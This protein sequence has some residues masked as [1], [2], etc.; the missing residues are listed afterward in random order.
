[1]TIRLSQRADLRLQLNS[2]GVFIK[3]REMLYNFSTFL[4]SCVQFHA[5]WMCNISGHKLYFSVFFK[6]IL[7]MIIGMEI[8]LSN[9]ELNWFDISSYSCTIFYILYN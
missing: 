8:I 5:I 2:L 1:M 6:E 9:L 3:L 4:I 7:K